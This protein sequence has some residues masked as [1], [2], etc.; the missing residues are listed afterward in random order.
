MSDTKHK[1]RNLAAT[2]AIKEAEQCYLCPPGI[3]WPA[4]AL[5]FD[6]VDGTKSKGVSRMM[7]DGYGLQAILAEVAK[8]R[9]VCAGHHRTLTRDRG[10]FG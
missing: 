1:Q 4:V 9:V 3:V 2:D 8:C 5:D 10:Q 7:R 6:H